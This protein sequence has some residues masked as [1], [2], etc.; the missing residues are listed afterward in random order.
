MAVRIRAGSRP[1]HDDH[2]LIGLRATEVRLDEGV[3][4]PGGGLDDRCSPFSGPDGHPPLVLRGDVGQHR[5]ADGILLP[6]RVEE[7]DDALRLLE[8]LNQ[9]VEQNA[10]ETPIRETDAI[11]VMLVEGVHGHPPGF[12]TRRISP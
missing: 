7:P 2:N 6:V 4:A 11:V 8:R 3:A 9:P 12:S 5:L 10:I 1:F